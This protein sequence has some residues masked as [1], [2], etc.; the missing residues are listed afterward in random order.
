MILDLLET[1]TTSEQARKI[2][3]SQDISKDQYPCEQVLEEIQDLC[4]ALSNLSGEGT[5]ET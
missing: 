4:A 3:A 2:N 5:R 1:S